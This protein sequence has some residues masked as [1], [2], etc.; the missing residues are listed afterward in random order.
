VKVKVSLQTYFGLFQNVPSL[1]FGVCLEGFHWDSSRKLQTVKIFLVNSF[2]FR[3]IKTA[4][5][6]MGMGFP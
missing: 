3:L 1:L 5:L 6:S 4:G 2:V